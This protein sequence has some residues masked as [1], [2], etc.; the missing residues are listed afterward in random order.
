MATKYVA[1]TAKE[2]EIPKLASKFEECTGMFMNHFH[3]SLHAL[4]GIWNR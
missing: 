1:N 2:N 3:C 4:G